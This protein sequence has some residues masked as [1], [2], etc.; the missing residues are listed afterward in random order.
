MQLSKNLTLAEMINSS[1]AKRK[2]IDNSPTS[3]HLE[4]MKYLAEKVFQPIREHFNVP[5]HISS[6]YRSKKLNE[7]IGGSLTSFHSSGCAID[8]DNDNSSVT[9]KEIFDYIKN[10]LDF[11]ELIWE[12]GTKDNPDW[13]HVAIVKGR[14]KEKEILKA[15]KEKNKPVYRKWKE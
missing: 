6:G 5:I 7:A 3:I 13:T 1:T 8:I 11:T 2:N 4:N 10:N 9:N 12:F 15:T 14:E